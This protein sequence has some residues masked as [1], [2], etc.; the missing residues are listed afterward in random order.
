M[1]SIKV[2]RSISAWNEGDL[3]VT[4]QMLWSNVNFVLSTAKLYSKCVALIERRK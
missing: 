1:L 4:A 3:H 2:W